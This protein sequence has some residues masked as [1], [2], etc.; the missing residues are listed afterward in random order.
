MITGGTSGIGRVAAVELAR[1]GARL[2]LVGRDR[3]RGE[4]TLQEIARETGNR[5]VELMLADL[6]SQRSIREC[7]ADFLSRSQ[8]LHLLVNNAGVFNLRRTVTVDGIE[9]VFAVNHLGYFLLTLLLLDRLKASAPA[10]IVNVASDAHHWGRMNFDDLG[11]ER[12]FRAMRIYGQS[13]LVNI[14][15]TYELARRIQG[16]G[17]TVNCLHPGAVA[18]RLGSNNGL[19]AKVLLPLLKPF[20]RTP[21]QG[22]RTTIYL[23]S[24]PEVEGVSGKY[25]VDGKQARSSGESCDESVARRLWDVS[26]QMTGLG[27]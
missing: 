8:P 7:A 25:F 11:G 6:S 27:A 10:R 5:E 24:S 21:E 15:F 13:K 12:S 17:V 14:L 4:E 20:M 22:A 23:A 2:V 26:A 9:S 1:K 18:T 19:L 3:A 16:S